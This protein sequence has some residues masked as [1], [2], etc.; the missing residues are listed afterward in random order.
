MDNSD[1]VPRPADE[2]M[3]NLQASGSEQVDR[4]NADD[5]RYPVLPVDSDLRHR[6]VR[7]KEQLSFF[8]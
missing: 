1:T 3:S 5:V 6:K 2:K 8:K 7:N 4:H